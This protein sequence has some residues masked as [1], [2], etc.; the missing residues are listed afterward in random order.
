[1]GEGI[2]RI[3]DFGYWILFDIWYHLS[4]LKNESQKPKKLKESP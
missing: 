4:L 1:M 2:F 3:W